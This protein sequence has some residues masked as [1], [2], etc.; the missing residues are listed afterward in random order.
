[1]ASTITTQTLVDSTSRTVI[2]VTG[3]G[4]GDANVKIIAAA[5]LSGALTSNG[6]NLL[7]LG[8]TTNKKSV[9]RTSVRRIWGQGQMAQGNNYV[10]LNWY[11]NSN[12]RIVTFGAGQF[13]YNFGTDGSLGS[14]SIPDSA[15]CTGDI[16]FTTS[17]GASDAWTVF[18]DLKKDGRDYSQGQHRDPRA[19]NYGTGYNGA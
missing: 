14:I 16:C 17:T 13:D 18:I 1:M 19:F 6:N 9:Y 3:T 12:T 5:N 15:N 11:G 4:S 8:D 10:S 2:K 7:T